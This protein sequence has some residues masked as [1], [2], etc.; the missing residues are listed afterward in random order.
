MSE[1]SS[2]L[3]TAAELCEHGISQFGRFRADAMHYID[4]AIAADDSYCTPLVVKACMLQGANDARFSD[5]ITN[6]VNLAYERLPVGSGVTAELLNSVSAAAKGHGVEAATVLMRLAKESPTDLFLQVLAQEQTFWLGKPEWMIKLTEQAAPAWSHTHKDYG[7]FLA[8][9]AF[10]HEEMGN[11]IKAEKYGRC[12]VEIDQTDVWGAHAVAH[13]L[14][15]KGEMRYGLDWL[16]G[17][18]DNWGQANQMRHHL[19]WHICLCLFEQGEYDR[20]VELLDTEI[21]NLNSH[22]VKSSPAATIDINNY[23]SLLMRLELYGVDVLSHWE[24]LHRLCA[25]RV[26]NHGSAFSNVHDMMVLTA[27]G[28]MQQGNALLLSMQQTFASSG[29]TTS[30]ALAYRT[31]A[32]PVCE[33]ILARWVQATLNVMC[34]IIYW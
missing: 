27:V 17:L 24:T 16:E 31:V 11:Y 25:Q 9:R 21:R 10:A 32:I 1:S 33:A 6:L 23:A 29:A 7:P 28:N 8:L 5:E 12:A 20:I 18:S 30:K 26:N 22:L 3:I 13:V 2:S 19:W 4:A 34:F 15:M 14:Y